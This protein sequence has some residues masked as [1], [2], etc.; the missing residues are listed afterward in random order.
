MVLLLTSPSGQPNELLSLLTSSQVPELTLVQDATVPLAASGSQVA[1]AIDATNGVDTNAGTPAAPLRTMAEFNRRYFG[2]V[3]TVAA[4]LQLVGDVIDTAFMPQAVTFAFGASLVVSG[5]RTALVSGV[6]V[7]SVT[8]LGNA[9]VGFPWQL[10]TTG[11]DWTT[12]PIGAQV[13]ITASTAPGNVDRFGFIASVTDANT[14]IVGALSNA[15]AINSSSV[16]TPLVNDVL[17]VSSLSRALPPQVSGT[18]LGTPNQNVSSFFVSRI[19]F[20]DLK[21]DSGY[22]HWLSGNVAVNFIG[23]E[24]VF[25]NTSIS[26]IRASTAVTYLACRFS[27]DQLVQP[28]AGN[29]YFSVVNSVISCD[30]ATKT[31]RFTCSGGIYSFARNTHNNAALRGGV[32]SRIE[33]TADINIRNTTIPVFLE[34]FT[35]VWALGVIGGSA[36]NLDTSIRVQSGSGFA[37][38]GAAARPTVLGTAGADEVRVGGTSMTYVALGTGFYAAFNNANPNSILNLVGPGGGCWMAQF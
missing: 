32:F 18:S 2:A 17:S 30:S 24:L 8:P 36:G 35:Q 25:L 9:G 3:V 27:M 10:V 29:Q 7:S 23:C 28:V 34:E 16:V 6:T 14:V 12:Q 22:V 5:T 21:L 31:N 26:T 37:W 38:N 13:R 33:I 4:T 1:W 11:I 19:T 20:R 15:T